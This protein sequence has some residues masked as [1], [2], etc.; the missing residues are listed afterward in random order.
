MEWRY[1]EICSSLLKYKVPTVPFKICKSFNA[2][3][4]ASSQVTSIIQIVIAISEA[5]WSIGSEG[6]LLKSL[7]NSASGNQ[8]NSIKEQCGL[9]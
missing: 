4:I 3:N 2:A 1:D 9:A 8:D 6:R 5:A 7:L